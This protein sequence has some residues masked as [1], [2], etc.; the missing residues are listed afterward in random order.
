MGWWW[1]EEL[2]EEVVSTSLAGVDM[3]E[4]GDAETKDGVDWADDS[5]AR[6]CNTR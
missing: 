3:E 4:A 2:E 5:A 1:G 6:Y